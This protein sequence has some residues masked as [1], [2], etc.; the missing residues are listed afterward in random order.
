MVPDERWIKIRKHLVKFM[1]KQGLG[2]PKV[3]A[4]PC[5][6]SR[7]SAFSQEPCPTLKR[8]TGAGGQRCALAEGLPLVLGQGA[9]GLLLAYFGGWVGHVQE[10]AVGWGW[11]FLLG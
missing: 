9:W 6:Q 10:E 11:V 8:K 3:L 4:H 2:L 7:V 5:R 1:Q